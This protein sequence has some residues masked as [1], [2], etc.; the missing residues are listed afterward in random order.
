MGESWSALLGV[1]FENIFHNNNIIIS[2]CS[3]PTSELMFKPHTPLNTHRFYYY[4]PVVAVCVVAF[5]FPSGRSN[6]CEKKS[7]TDHDPVTTANNHSSI[8]DVAVIDK[9]T[10]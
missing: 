3:P 4:I 8:N 10:N 9:K 6:G 7:K 5:L 1:S 2:I